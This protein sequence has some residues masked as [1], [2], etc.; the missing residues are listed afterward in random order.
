MSL[1]FILMMFA[2]AMAVLAICLAINVEMPSPRVADPDVY[3][4]DEGDGEAFDYGGSGNVSDNSNDDQDSTDLYLDMLK[5][6]KQL[7]LGAGDR[8]NQENCDE[9]HHFAQMLAKMLDRYD[10]EKSLSQPSFDEPQ[11]DDPAAAAAAA[12]V[13]EAGQVKK[14]VDET[15]EKV[16]K[17][18]ISPA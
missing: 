15:K 1:F 13:E 12:E 3:V 4:D 11:A 14:E 9:Y 17:A 8:T 7:T 2:V 16:E 6:A 5:R 18:P 10:L